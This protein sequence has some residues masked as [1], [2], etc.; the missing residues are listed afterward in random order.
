MI[1]ADGSRSEKGSH[2]LP[3]ISPDP[4][5]PQSSAI[6]IM[7]LN[8]PFCGTYPTKWGRSFFALSTHEVCEMQV[9]YCKQLPSFCKPP[10]KGTKFFFLFL[11]WEACNSFVALCNPSHTPSLG[12]FSNLPVLRLKPP[13]ERVGRQELTSPP[14]P[15]DVTAWDKNVSIL[16][17]FFEMLPSTPTIRSACTIAP[18]YDLKIGT[19]GTSKHP[20]FL[21]EVGTTR[22]AT[23]MCLFVCF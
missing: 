3:I 21:L 23:K 7:T 22:T 4:K 17:H 2:L 15:R 14:S 8:V 16:Q 13:W 20:Y 1:K 12:G 5:G 11:L 6:S 9:S 18:R 19:I 10:R